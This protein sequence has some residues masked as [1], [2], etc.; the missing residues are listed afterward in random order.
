M[1]DD[2]IAQLPHF[3]KLHMAQRLPRAGAK[4]P[5]FSDASLAVFSQIATLESLEISESDS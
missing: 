5:S 2:L 4:A 1:G 3:T